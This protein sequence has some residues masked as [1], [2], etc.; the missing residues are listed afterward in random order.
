MSQERYKNLVNFY[1][2]VTSNPSSTP[3]LISGDASFRKFYRVPEGIIMD[4]PPT[5]EK[6]HEFVK[7]ANALNAAQILAP[8]ILATDYEQGFLLVSDLGDEVFAK[9]TNACKDSQARVALYKEAINLVVKF[10]D[11]QVDDLPIYDAE[12][13]ARED[14]ICLDYYFQAKNYVLK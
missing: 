4:A 12:F 9:V 7:I 5:T 14:N 11:I 8:K 10:V 6:N 1:R 3:I 2:K 13:I